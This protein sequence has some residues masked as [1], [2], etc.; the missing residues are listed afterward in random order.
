VDV[1]PNR[2]NVAIEMDKKEVFQ[3]DWQILHLDALCNE[4][5]SCATFCPYD[6]KPYKDKLTLFTIM[7]DF[8]NSKNNG[9]IITSSS[10]SQMITLRLKNNLWKLK[11]N[12]DGK[13][14]PV[15]SQCPDDYDVKELKKASAI[16]S[17]AFKDYSYLIN[18][19]IN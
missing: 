15:D 19:S 2:A 7:E 17:I 14:I 10:G 3:D 9:F 16:I 12:K 8:K 11:L 5:G 13:L 1:C 6:G 4:C 18:D